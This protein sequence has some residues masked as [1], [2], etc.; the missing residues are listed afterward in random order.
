MKIKRRLLAVCTLGLLISCSNIK[1]A[2][3]QAQL[4]NP[5]FEEDVANVG[6]PDD[7]SIGKEA[8]VKVVTGN[9]S[10]GNR[11]L[12]V[13]DGYVAVYQDLQIP[14]LADQQL[15]FSIDAKS[16]SKNA[17]IGARIGY[18]TTDN[19]WHDSV[20]LWN[21]PITAEY[22]TYTASRTFPANAKAG[23][24]YIAIYR[25][26]KKS[27]F[28][29][30]NAQLQIGAGLSEEDAH[31]AVTLARDAQYFLNRLDVAS[32]INIVLPQKDSWQKQAQDILQKATNADASLAAKLDEYQQNIA[33]LNAQLFGAMAKGKPFISATSFAFDRLAPDAIPVKSTFDGKVLSLRGEHQAFGIDIANATNAPQKIAI[34][35]QGLP[36]GCNINWRRQV[37]TETW[38]TKGKTLL[39]DPLTQLPNNN[40]STFINVDNGEIARLFADI[41]INKTAKAGNYP[42]TITLT[43]NNQNAETQT[44]NLQILPQAAPTPRMTHYEFGYNSAFPIANYTA[45]AVKDLV[46]HGVTDIEW[47][48]MPPAVFD[49]QG[50]L[51]TVNFASYNKMLE[52]F[53]SSSIRL[54]IFWQPSYLKF[55]TTDGS[56]LKVLSPEWKNALVQIINAWIKDAQEHHIPPAQITILTKDEIHSHSL[57]S[58][59]DAS[60]DEYVQIAKLLHE[61]IPNLK[62]YLTLTF[63][64]F[65]NDVKAVL[66][67][68]DVVMPHMPQPEKLTRNAPP[69]YNPYKTF[70]D[71]IY[72]MLFA[73]Q[74][75]RGL[76]IS[77]YHVA[78]GRSDNLLQWNR[79]YP[80]LAAA[81]D[82]TGIAFWAYNGS[83]GSSWDDTDKGLLDYNFVY[84]GKEKNPLCQK[85]NITGETIVPSI[86]WEA[87]RSG[88]QDANI[89]LAL[90]KAKLTTAQQAEFATLL[91]EAQKHN[92]PQRSSTNDISLTEM[93]ELSRQLRKLYTGLS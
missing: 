30:D 72:P 83:R 65:P 87:V 62:N 4:A 50:N 93:Q 91:A 90:Q 44:V 37:F 58:S 24:L 32:K 77:S 71:E 66:P 23:R 22:Q 52:K 2:A 68:V 63:Y 8:Q 76:I 74:K 43:G 51:Q 84:N 55:K 42:L 18:S 46:S 12:L 45:D 6:N 17:V 82:H 73:E 59:P 27:T 7:W 28:Y 60:I 26:D 21:K 79:F 16:V 61:K 89:I 86:R 38:Y 19:K 10:A 47:A 39:A 3:A 1:P 92:G 75:K 13:S 70:N 78:A 41:E 11:A 53:S 64:A 25:S 49:T 34:N 54:N 85:Y 56:Y 67:Y 29:I 69:S 14:K 88:L 35:V 36:D 48:Y 33:S 80:V 9:A 57:D 15:R 81:T 40:K 31:R 20:L 5:S